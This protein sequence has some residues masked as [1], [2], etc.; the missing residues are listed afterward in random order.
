MLPLFEWSLADL[1]VPAVPERRIFRR[2]ARDVC[3]SAEDKTAVELIVKE[4]PAITDGSFQVTRT[5]C[6]ALEKE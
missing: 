4:R 5:N 3:R 6:A 2:V 1:N